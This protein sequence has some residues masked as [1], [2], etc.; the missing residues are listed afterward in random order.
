MTYD[1]QAKNRNPNFRFEIYTVANSRD[2][3]WV[4][5]NQ[6]SSAGQCPLHVILFIC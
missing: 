4:L 5:W 3:G 2:R 1:M 6:I